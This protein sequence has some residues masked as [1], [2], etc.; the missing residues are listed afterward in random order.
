MTES[1]R[2]LLTL[3]C[4]ECW[5]EFEFWNSGVSN[6]CKHCRRWFHWKQEDQDELRKQKDRTFT[7]ADDWELVREK[8][9]VL[10][11]DMFVAWVKH[12]LHCI[13]HSQCS[14]G[15]MI[16]KDALEVWLPL[17]VEERCQLACDFGKEVLGW[18]S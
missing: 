9:I 11:L 2:K 3:A 6:I 8:V 12:Q 17:S 7:H 15:D 18:K 10:N 4:G 13:R 14:V 5:H 1:D 16:P